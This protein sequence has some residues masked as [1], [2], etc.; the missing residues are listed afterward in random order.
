MTLVDR[1]IGLSSG[2]SL[3]YVEHGERTGTPV[4]FLHG[5]SDSWRSFE[6]VLPLLP[7]TIRALAPSQRGH[8][9]SSRPASG[10]GPG[11]LARDVEAFLDALGIDAAIV[12]GHSMGSHVAQRVAIAHPGRVRGLV[13]VGS[14]ASLRENPSVAELGPAI[15]SLEDPVD[16]EFI[17]GFQESTV[18]KPVAPGLIETAVEESAKL[19]AAVWRALL[20]GMLESDT[21]AE[22]GRIGAPTLLLWGDRDAIFGRADQDALFAGIRGARLLVYAGNGHSPH[23]EDPVRFAADV[24]AF[25]R[26][27]AP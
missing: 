1:T 24:T 14:Y 27:V 25:V 19:P 2:P 11:D 16:R 21:T 17:R 5:Y 20:E 8:G 22:L 4:L 15:T 18:A 12:V 10:Y 23:W 26:T 3:S 7:P 9:D 13:L 6:S